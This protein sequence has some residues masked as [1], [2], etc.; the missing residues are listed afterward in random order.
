M[1]SADIWVSEKDYLLTEVTI[2]GIFPNSE[3]FY[4]FH[5]KG[6]YEVKPMGQGFNLSRVL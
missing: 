6:E 4:N 5:L 3:K 1:T 2:T